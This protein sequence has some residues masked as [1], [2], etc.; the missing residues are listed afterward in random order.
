MKSASRTSRFALAWSVLLLSP[1]LAQWQN[2]APG[3]DYQE[4]TLSDPNNVFVARLERSNTNCIID[5]SIAQGQ[6]KT[7]FETVSGM[8]ARYDDTINYWGQYWGQR[9]DVVVAIN[10]DFYNTTTAIP[11][12]GQ[13][14]SGWYAKRFSD[15]TGGSGFA[16]QLDRDVFIGECVRHISSKQKVAFPGTGGSMN[17]NAINTDRAENQLILYTPQY[18]PSTTIFPP[19]L[20]G[21]HVVVEMSRPTLILPAPAYASGTIT[22]ITENQIGHFI[23]FDHVVFWG[24]GTAGSALLSNAS[25]GAEVRISQEITHYEHDCATSLPL[26]WTKTYAA[27]GGSYHFLKNG[28]VQTF[29]DPG[30]IARHPRTAVAYDANYVY[31][32]VVD[33]RS[34]VSEG[35]NMTELGNFCI[36]YL[37]ATEGINQDGGGSSTMWVNGQVENN[38]SDG[39][40][41]SVA[42]GL[43][44]IIPQAMVQSSR[45]SADHHVRTPVSADGRL[46]P[47][48]NYYDHATIQ[49]GTAG[50][51]VDHSLK[52]VLATGDYWWKC[53]FDA[54]V[55]WVTEDSLA[56]GAVPGDLDADGDV[57]LGDYTLFVACLN[58]PDVATPPPGCD[59]T[60][61]SDADF[62]G[63]D[64]VDLRDVSTFQDEFSGT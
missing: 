7:G 33:G 61:F 20:L 18:G 17:I 22:E 34:P 51:V 8:A 16:W 41:R 4:F 35:M 63:D 2:V 5:S 39:S 55:A 21:V 11:T 46:G 49:S 48:T 43:M 27:V 15:F 31:F 24:H 57:D 64:D 32:I 50:I 23:P 58:G 54:T 30:A 42:N 29:T 38:P 56:K 6:L 40:E 26:D 36:N 45:F 10:G 62:D 1:A 59:P 28:V 9:N 53:Q 52:G 44:M 3:I 14:H 47:G 25:V 19:P 13:I 37:G 12:G 60:D